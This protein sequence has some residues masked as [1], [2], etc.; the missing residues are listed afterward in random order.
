MNRLILLFVALGL[1]SC[2]NDTSYD[3]NYILQPYEQAESGGDWEP[4]EGVKA[5]VFD[6]NT[7]DW[8]IASYD[9]ALAGVITSVAGEEQRGPIAW[10]TPYGDSETELSLLLDREEVIIVAV[11]PATEVYAY[12]AYVV[13]VNYSEIFATLYFYAW[14]D[15]SY[16]Y[17]KWNVIMPEVPKDELDE[18][19]DDQDADADEDADELD[20]DELT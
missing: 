2:F 20:T 3:T 13:P 18:D 11:D 5:Y 8:Y 1:T 10:S 16:T 12:L 9:D 15:A 7:D 19:V 14:K 17:S 4:L 6:G